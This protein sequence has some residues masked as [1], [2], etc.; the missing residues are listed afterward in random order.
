M[1]R[2][3]SPRRKTKKKG[4]AKT[5][6]AP[7]GEIA[8]PGWVVDFESF[9]RWLHSAD[10]P[11][12]GKISFINNVVWAD[13]TMEEFYDHGEVIVEISRVLANLMKESQFGKFGKEGTRY[14]H[15][16]TNLSTE[17]DGIVFSHAALANGRV[18]FRG[19]KKGDK[20]ELVGSP[21]IVIE[22]ISKSS[23]LKDSE[24][25]LAAYFDA[26]IEEYWLI[27][28]REEDEIRFD[29]FKRNKKE[30]HE[31]RKQQGWVKSGVL[32]KTFRLVQT[33][34]AGGDPEYTLEVR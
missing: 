33:E 6:V 7:N 28:A 17:P 16:E 14:S 4:L 5:I 10:F 18:K 2:L 20:T 11:E 23:D 3:L 12:C 21:E 9:R 27:D 32:G 34:D 29:V 22:V 24:W 15:L 8:I 31:S 13:L 25:L 30:F 1:S 26:G 19:G